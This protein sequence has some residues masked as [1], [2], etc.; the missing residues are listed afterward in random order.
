[1]FWNVLAAGHI[2]SDEDEERRRQTGE[3]GRVGNDRD[4]L[5]SDAEKKMCGALEVVRK[6]VGANNMTAVA[7]AYTMHKVPYA[8]PIIG[9]RKIEH[10]MANIEALDISI[11]PEQIKYLDESSTFNIGFPHNI[12]HRIK[13]LYNNPTLHAVSIHERSGS[14]RRGKRLVF[15]PYCDRPLSSNIEDLA[16]GLQSPRGGRAH[17]YFQLLEVSNESSTGPSTPFGSQ[18]PPRNLNGQAGIAT[19]NMAEGYFEAFFREEHRLEMGAN[20]SV[21][22][23]QHLLD[24][25]VLGRFAV[26]KIVV[27]QSHDYLANALRETIHH[28]NII[29]Y[30]HAWLDTCRFSLFGPTV[31]TLFILM[32]WAE[33]GSLDDFIRARLGA[34]NI[35]GPHSGTSEEPQSRSVRICAFRAAQVR[36]ELRRARNSERHGRAVH[37]LSADGTDY[38]PAT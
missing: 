15:C 8:F 30:H 31:P 27:G 23:C 26:K 22:L 32:Q 3:K 29:T 34:S 36:P 4:W 28:P 10:L 16:S 20:G 37:F 11:N 14:S 13:L 17:N 7:I 9:R 2:R 18:S 21:F 35:D 5:R 19:G 1:M 38:R 25:N 33:S 6:Q 12:L 24:G